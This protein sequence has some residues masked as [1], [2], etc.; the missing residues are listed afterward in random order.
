MRADSVKHVIAA[1]L[2]A[3]LALCGTSS[4]SAIEVTCADPLDADSLSA[5][6]DAAIMELLENNG[7]FHGLRTSSGYTH[8]LSVLSCTPDA[9]RWKYPAAAT[10]TGLLKRVLET[11]ELKVAGVKWSNGGAADYKSDP[12]NPTG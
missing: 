10:A 1:T 8:A 6:V 9:T 7:W 2:L 5:A 12:E 4:V 11:G 3:A